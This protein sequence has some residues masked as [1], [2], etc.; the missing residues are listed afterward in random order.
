[1]PLRP[2]QYPAKN[3]IPPVRQ[4]TDVSS[5]AAAAPRGET[6]CR[7]CPL[8]PLIVIEHDLRDQ[9]QPVEAL[10]HAGF[11]VDAAADGPY[12]LRRARE[13]AYAALTLDPS[14]PGRRGFELLEDI[15]SW[16]A[17]H[18]APVVGV[19]MPVDIDT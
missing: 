14:P 17:S 9:A 11:E 7:N 16:G 18:A 1:M 4:R 5:E 10:S 6:A 8:R 12:A 19:T 3:P 15:R 2:F 13:T